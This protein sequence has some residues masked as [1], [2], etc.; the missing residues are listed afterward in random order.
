[1]SSPNHLFT[2]SATSCGMHNNKLYDDCGGNSTTFPQET[3]YDS[4]RK[5][6]VSFAFWM[7]STCGAPR[8]TRAHRLPSC[9]PALLLSMHTLL[10]SI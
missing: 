8:V 2:Q 6:N 5:H 4:L 1:M 10:S 7:N 3:I 9:S